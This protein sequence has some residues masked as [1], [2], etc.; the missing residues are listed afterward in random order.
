M[1]LVLLQYRPNLGLTNMATELAEELPKIVAPALNINGR[2]NLNGRVLPEDVT[3]WLVPGG[4]H[5]QNVKD[6]EIMIWAHDFPERKMTLEVRKN[7]VIEG[8]Q[9][10]LDDRLG[11]PVSGFVWI[12]LQPS[13]YGQ[14]EIQGG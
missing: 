6:L 13:A 8:V 12:L 10:F 7:E 1:P 2:E 5:D 11:R 9:R 4:E 14:F 3:V